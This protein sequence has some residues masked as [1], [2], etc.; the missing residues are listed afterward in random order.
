MR[1][2]QVVGDQ[3]GRLG[4]RDQHRTDDQVG[5][6]DLLLDRVRAGHQRLQP[7]LVDA[8]DLGESLGVDVEDR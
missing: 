7:A 2:D 8:V 5:L 3:L 1:R 4:A 6:G